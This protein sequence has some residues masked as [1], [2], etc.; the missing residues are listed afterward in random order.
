MN[1]KAKKPWKDAVNWKRFFFMILFAVIYNVAEMVFAAVVII[2]AG[3]TLVTGARNERLLRFGGQLS[4]YVYR[5]F[6]YLT[7][8]IEEKPFPFSDWPEYKVSEEAIAPPPPPPPAP[9]ASPA[10]PAE[11]GAEEK[12][13]KRK[14]GRK[15]KKAKQEKQEKEEQPEK[16]E[17]E[18]QQEKEESQN[19]EEKQE[20]QKEEKKE[21]KEP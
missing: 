16:Q 7:Y 8:N 21:E 5:I 14:P 10:E 11:E 4:A 15:G 2:Q 9:A 18:A 6:Q 3:F 19:K 13:V 1:D 17:K 12:Q 20:E